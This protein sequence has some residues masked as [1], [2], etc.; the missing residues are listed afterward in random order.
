MKRISNREIGVFFAR[1]STFWAMLK[2]TLS[3]HKVSLFALIRWL[4]SE[5][6]PQKTRSN[7][8]REAFGVLVTHFS[9]V[10]FSKTFSLSR[11]ELLSLRG[12]RD[13]APEIGEAK[14]EVFPYLPDHALVLSMQVEMTADN[15]L[16]VAYD[17]V[18]WEV[19]LKKHLRDEPSGGARLA[20]L[21][22][23]HFLAQH[24]E[25]IPEEMLR[26]EEIFEF[27]GTR[28]MR[29]DVLSGHPIS[30]TGAVEKLDS[31]A[32]VLNFST[33]YCPDPGKISGT[34]KRWMV[35]LVA[36]EPQMDGE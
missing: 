30:I 8:F 14:F 31:D 10:K 16:F 25:Y 7:A 36:S 18:R 24:P 2:V 15:R 35:V 26:C 9:R 32:H 19:V 22:L 4:T 20:S 17:G 21:S 3:E 23:A 29:L 12:L 28:L 27:Q 11:Q 34:E 1:L 5:D 33:A 6:D 13:I